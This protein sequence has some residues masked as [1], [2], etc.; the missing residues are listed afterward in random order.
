MTSSRSS[1]RSALVRAHG[2]NHRSPSRGGSR[3]NLIQ[4]ET[5]DMEL[6]TAHVLTGF[7]ALSHRIALTPGELRLL[8]ESGTAL[9]PDLWHETRKT[10]E[11]ADRG[12]AG[13]ELKIGFVPVIYAWLGLQDE[14]EFGDRFGGVGVDEALAKDRGHLAVAAASLEGDRSTPLALPLSHAW[15]ARASRLMDDL[16]E[17]GALVLLTLERALNGCPWDPEWSRPLFEAIVQVADLIGDEQRLS[18]A[19]KM[20]ATIDREAAP[21]DSKPVPLGVV[22]QVLTALYC[23]TH[24]GLLLIDE[25]A[26]DS[27]I[28]PSLD[29]W[30]RIVDAAR[31]GRV[32][33]GDIPVPVQLLRAWGAPEDLEQEA[34]RDCLRRCASRLPE[35]VLEI[36]RL[37][38]GVESMDVS[39]DVARTVVAMAVIRH[40]QL[41]HG[42]EPLLGARNSIWF[43]VHQGVRRTETL[44]RAQIIRRMWTVLLRGEIDPLAVAAVHLDRAGESQAL[45]AHDETRAHLVEVMHWTA[46][47]EGEQHRRDHG[48]VCI[49]QYLFLSGNPEEAMRRLRDLEGE[50]AKSLLR[51]LEARGDARE[52]VRKAES[53]YAM[54]GDIH[55]LRALSLCSL[56]AGHSFRADI[57][58]RDHCESHPDD[59]LA[60]G[61]HASLLF[62]LD[63][64]RDAVVAA[65]RALAIGPDDTSGRSVLAR[66]LSRTGSDG[67]EEATELAVS[68]LLADDVLTAVPRE[69]MAD[70]V[71]VAHYGGVRTFS[72]PAVRTT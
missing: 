71:D 3:S 16:P 14:A 67:R 51:G 37:W 42:F 41:Q 64:F 1:H 44:E 56:R 43:E 61:F 30:A 68:V 55:S 62:E 57:V 36:R 69:V 6:A 5:S 48:T 12:G 18:S 13:T 15:S 35:V 11:L 52:A 53:E 31:D 40:Q 50:Q 2:R 21:D 49:A 8:D 65:R 39:E 58:S 26:L 4:R 70:L 47:Y 54:Q 25:R 27:G 7:Y 33:V 34:V 60:W 17:T 63:R 22:T 66:C 23:L 46:Q 59:G 19:R 32:G 29:N 28:D 10:L 38:G 24:E 20:L 9:S 45:G 72:K